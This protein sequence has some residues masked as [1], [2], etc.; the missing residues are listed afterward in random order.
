MTL[1]VF[2]LT[3]AFGFGYVVIFF[4]VLLFCVGFN[5]RVLLIS[6]FCRVV[7]CCVVLFGDLYAL[8]L[9]LIVI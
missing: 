2:G 5:L 4:A 9:K 6:F 8:T 7:Y 3:L 1:V